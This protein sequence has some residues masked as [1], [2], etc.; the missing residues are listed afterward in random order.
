MRAIWHLEL[1]WGWGG[2]RGDGLGDCPT[3]DLR[4][5]VGGGGIKQKQEYRGRVEMQESILPL[6]NL[7]SLCPEG[8]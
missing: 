6:M 5:D 8:N 3:P 7:R 4:D 1:D 2:W